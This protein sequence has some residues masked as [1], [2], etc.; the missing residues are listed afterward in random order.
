MNAI[1]AQ[2]CQSRDKKRLQTVKIYQ[3]MEETAR[4]GTSGFSYCWVIAVF[5]GKKQLSVRTSVKAKSC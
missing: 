5:G 4:T 2:M 1:T 3:R